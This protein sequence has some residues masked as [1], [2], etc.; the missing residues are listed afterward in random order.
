MKNIFYFILLCLSIQL[1]Y[2]NSMI[3]DNNA[4]ALEDEIA[5]ADVLKLEPE[6]MA[7]RQMQSRRYDTADEQLLLDTAVAVFQDT[8]FIINEIEP[9]TGTVLGSKARDCC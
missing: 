9:I 3:G 4:N 7:L 1:S 5:A 2:G 8:G 6:S